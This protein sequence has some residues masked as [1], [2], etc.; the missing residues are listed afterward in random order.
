MIQIAQLIS[1][2][3]FLLTA[4]AIITIGALLLRGI[5]KDAT[6]IVAALPTRS[7]KE[8]TSEAREANRWTAIQELVGAMSIRAAPGALLILTGVGLIVWICWN[9]SH[10]P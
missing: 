4:V 3:L 10:F 2:A 8:D 5:A 7:L 6:R 9:H 1:L